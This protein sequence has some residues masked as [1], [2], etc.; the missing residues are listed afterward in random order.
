MGGMPVC[1]E[2]FQAANGH[3]FPLHAPYA[4]LLAL[5]FLGAY[6]AAHGGQAAGQAD[7]AIGFLEVTLADSVDEFRNVNM[8]RASRHAGLMLAVQATLG[9]VHG[10]G[11]VIAKGNL[12]K[13]AFPLL[14]RLMGHGMLGRH[15]VRH[16]HCTSL[17]S[18][19]QVSS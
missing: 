8:H 5:A 2:T 10:S 19:L 14:C 1:Y 12:L 11:F 7:D 17:A 6:P 15:H 13:V 16:G 4:L 3:S 18:K 9:L